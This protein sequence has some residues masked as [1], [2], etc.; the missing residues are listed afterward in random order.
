MEGFYGNRNGVVVGERCG[1][2]SFLLGFWNG[3]DL[4]E[5][6]Y[7]GIRGFGGGEKRWI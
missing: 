4:V 6:K 5:R 3:I 2:K 1:F 7:G